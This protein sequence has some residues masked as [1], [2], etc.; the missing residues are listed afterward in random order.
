MVIV[1]KNVNGAFCTMNYIELMNIKEECKKKKVCLFGA[2]VYGTTWAYDILK[3]AEINIDFYYDNYRQTGEEIR[4]GVKIISENS[5]YRLRDFVFVFVAM[6]YRHQ[7]LIREQLYK[8]GIYNIV[9]M[10]DLFLQTFII[11]LLQKKDRKLIKQFKCITDNR[12]YINRQFRYYIGYYP[13]LQNP[14]TFNEKIQ[15]LKLYDRKSE[16]TQLVDKYEVKNY[17]AEKIGEGYIIPTLGLYDSFAEID[18]DKLPRQFVLKCTHDSGSVVIC[19]DKKNFDIGNAHRILDRGLSRNYYWGSREWPYKNVK[20]RIIAE[21][22]LEE[23]SEEGIIDYK[24]LCM[25]GK[26]KIVFT[27]SNRFSDSGLCVNF[28]DREWN[29]MLFERHYPRRKK[30]I[31]K[32]KKYEEMVEISEKLSVGIK[33]VRVDLYYIQERIYVGELTFY[34][35]SGLEEFTPVEWDYRLGEMIQL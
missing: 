3:A 13:D 30:E 28:Y 29:A 34:P 9:E 33:F 26:V 31:E 23:L 22:F 20:P 7:R 27:C 16:Y 24:F 5:L 35:G 11:D 25:D 8:N 19:K 4:D 10:D 6:S 21:Q 2:G 15:W 32:P 18:F 1:R 12:E 17:I 14:K